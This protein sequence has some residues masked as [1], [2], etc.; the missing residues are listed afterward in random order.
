MFGRRPM[1]PSGNITVDAWIAEG[2][3]LAAQAGM[4]R[5]LFCLTRRLLLI[6]HTP[7]SGMAK[8]TPCSRSSGM[9]RH[10]RC[11]TGQPPS[12][13]MMPP[14]ATTQDMSWGSWSG[15]LRRLRQPIGQLPLHPPERYRRGITKATCWK[16]LVGMTKPWKH[17]IRRLR[18]TLI[19]RL[20]GLAK[21]M[22]SINS[23]G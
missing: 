17:T 1:E 15:M 21:G 5:Q 19:P 4:R 23:G 12:L 18:W 6:R 8:A 9:K 11:L 3:E 20:P 22:F 13:R 7:L 14:H 10:W 2:N 16:S